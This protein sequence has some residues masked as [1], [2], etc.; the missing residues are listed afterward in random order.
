MNKAVIIIAEAGVNH[1]GD[2]NTAK[3]MIDFAAISNVDFIKFQTWITED[4]IDISAEK[5]EYQKVND[6]IG[7]QFEMAKKLELSF[8][9]FRELSRYCNVKK[10]KFLST[11]EDKKSLDF[12]SDELNLEYLKI[13]SGELDNIPFLRN[14]GKK[15][16]DIIL[17]TG[18]ANIGEIENAINELTKF[19]AKSITLLHCTTSYPAPLSTVNLKAMNTLANTFKLPVGYSDHTVGIEISLAAVSLG[20]TVIEKHFT[21]DKNMSGP[22]HTASLDTLELSSLVKSIRNIEK[23]LEGNGKKEIQKIEINNKE[24]IRKGIYIN[25]DL[26]VGDIITEDDL[27]YK[28]PALGIE[29]NHFDLIINKR[30]RTNKIKGQPLFLKDIDFI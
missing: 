10:V 19:G 3:K 2:I 20:A 16:K 5:A 7:S 21:L 27:I 1:N 4:N 25:K 24:V 22:D 14:V 12:L 28:R 30:L 13:G 26:V 6:G 23:A 9:D 17:S 18:M 8:D 11:P 15:H 29:L